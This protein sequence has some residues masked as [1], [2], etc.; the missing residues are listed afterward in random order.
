RWRPPAVGTR[1]IGPEDRRLTGDTGPAHGQLH[2]VADGGVPGRAHAPDV[3]GLDG[4]LGEHGAIAADHA[5]LA[6]GGDLEGLVVRAVFL[7]RLG[8]QADVADI[9]H[10]AH[11][12][13][14]QGAAVVDHRLVDAGIA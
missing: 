7:G 4:V 2:P 14:T 10:G 8:H 3:A 13:G 11:V 9:A 5:H 1:L 12:V 6:G